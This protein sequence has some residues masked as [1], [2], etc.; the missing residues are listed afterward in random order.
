MRRTALRFD[1]PENLYTDVRIE[2]SLRAYYTMQDE[3]VTGNGEVHVVGAM[4]RVFDGRMWYSAETN[5]IDSIQ[6]KIDELAE[7][8]KP[9]KKILEHPVVRNFAV[10]KASVLRFGGEGCLR[11]LGKGDREEIVRSYHAEC[12]DTA[13]Q[14]IKM[15]HVYFNAGN[16]RKSLYT[17]KGT[18]IESDYQRCMLG[19]WYNVAGK[20]GVTYG[21]GKQLW[22]FGIDEIRGRESEVLEERARILDFARNNVPVEPG[23]YVCVL[24]PSVTSVFTH[25]SFGHK[26]EADFMLNDKKLRE[27]WTM[28]KLVANPKVSIV[29]EGDTLHHGYCPYDDEGNKKK[30]VWLIKDGILSGRLHDAKS[31][32]ALGEEPTGNARAQDYNCTPMVRMTNTYMAAGK[33]DPEEIVRGVKDGVYVYDCNYGTG[34][35]TFTI[36]PQKCYRIRDGKLAEPLHVNVV[37]GSVFQ[38]LFDID[39]VGTDLKFFSGTCGK[40]GQSLPTAIGGPTIRVKKL[41]VN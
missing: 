5:D 4:V 27:E 18:E 34:Q 9:D 16:I 8:A 36:Q 30:D 6:S 24:S 17:S 39:A 14:E 26:S 29:D 35:S 15:H 40:C 38:T 41:M 19:V 23:E 10:N 7:L 11:A 31:A 2:D 28:G 20:G 21:G 25:E 3:D 33:D 32:A 22:G 1:F 13:L 12:V 37:T